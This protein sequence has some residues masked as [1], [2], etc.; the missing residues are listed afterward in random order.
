MMRLALVFGGSG[1][2]GQAICGHFI[3]QGSRVIGVGRANNTNNEVPEW[4]TW[5]VDDKQFCQDLEG[6]LIESKIDCAHFT[7]LKKS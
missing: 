5:G 6:L 7:C 2:I 1:S 3:K 4:V